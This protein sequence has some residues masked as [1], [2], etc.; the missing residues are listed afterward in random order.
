MDL[1]RLDFIDKFF[2][3]L[4]TPRLN[5]FSARN[6]L[7][8]FSIET[9]HSCKNILIVIKDLQDGHL[10]VLLKQEFAQLKRLVETSKITLEKAKSRYETLITAWINVSSDIDQFKT[11]IEQ[12][13]Q[14]GTDENERWQAKLRGAVYGPAAGVTV[15]MIIADIFGF[16]GEYILDVL[17]CQPFKLIQ[18][19][20]TSK[21][22]EY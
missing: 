3:G 6:D 2:S 10:E 12:A 1:E 7:L 18:V 5:L 19:V 21:S 9:K 11:K 17:W 22:H 20:S 16:L 8:E 4:R 15:G 13:L 14:K